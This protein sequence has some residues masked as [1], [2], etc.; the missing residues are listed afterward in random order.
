[1]FWISLVTFP[2]LVDLW[3]VSIF[4]WNETWAIH[5][6]LLISTH[7]LFYAVILRS[8]RLVYLVVRLLVTVLDGLC[9]NA[10]Y[11]NYLRDC[12][13]QFLWLLS[14]LLNLISSI[15]FNVIIVWF[16]TTYALGFSGCSSVIFDFFLPDILPSYY[17][18]PATVTT[19]RC[20][21]SPLSEFCICNPKCLCYFQFLATGF[22]GRMP[23][24]LTW[25][26]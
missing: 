1:M 25:A 24:P 11:T 26:C 14:L 23:Y 6:V 18:L 7:F 15:T 2:A 4:A 12:Y 19:S 8:L 5:L 16:V 13:D 3:L 22:N 9:F 10:K 20:G 17:Y 21:C